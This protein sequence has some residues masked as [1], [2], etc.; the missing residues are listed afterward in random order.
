MIPRPKAT[1]KTTA[2]L[3]PD[4]PEQEPP[5]PQNLK[6][7]TSADETQTLLTN[8]S[9]SSSDDSTTEM[10][11]ENESPQEDPTTLKPTPETPGTPAEEPP[12]A[13]KEIVSSDE[14]QTLSTNTSSSIS[15]D[16]TTDEAP[17]EDSWNPLNTTPDNADVGEEQVSLGLTESLVIRDGSKFTMYLQDGVSEQPLYYQAEKKSGNIVVSSYDPTTKKDKQLGI[18]VKKNVSKLSL[19]YSLY[20]DD[21]VPVSSI[22]Y[23]IPSFKQALLDAQPRSAKVTLLDGTNSKL[24]T[25]EPHE[26]KD[27]KKGLTMNGRGRQGSRK[28]MQLQSKNGEV[29]LQLAKWDKHHYHLDFQAPFEPFEAFGLALAQ[30]DL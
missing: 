18:L 9:S 6:E 4:K 1:S 3:K 19:V 25:K 26:K 24:E 29:V 22:N 16:S 2:V 27:G 12:H 11:V 20:N 7:N 21:C 8:S 30:F 5:H 14:T 10:P 23:N 17:Q 15:D 28:N 13:L